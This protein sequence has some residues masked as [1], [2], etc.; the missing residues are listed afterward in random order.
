MDL[1][2]RKLVTYDEDTLH[3]GAKPADPPMRLIGVAAV[4]KNP[5]AGQGYVEDLK[6]VIREFGPKLGKL[7]TDRIIDLAGGGDKIEAYGKACMAGT[8]C[9]TQ[10]W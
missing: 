4:V 10:Y 9:V 2:I 6:P 3:E 1:I 8:D 5:W 7:L